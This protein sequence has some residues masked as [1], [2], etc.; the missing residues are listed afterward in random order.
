MHLL[1]INKNVCSALHLFAYCDC[2]DDTSSRTRM[3]SSET[4]N[5]KTST[6]EFLVRWSDVHWLITINVLYQR[7]H[8]DKNWR[9]PG[10]IIRMSK[11]CISDPYHEIEMLISAFLT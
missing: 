4:K 5:P 8:R 11:K 2:Y 10:Q 9:E 1:T 6:A 3:M 7:K